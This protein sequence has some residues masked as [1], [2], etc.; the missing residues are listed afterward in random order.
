MHMLTRRL[1]DEPS[2]RYEVETTPSPLQASPT[3]PTDPLATATLIVVASNP[4][5]HATAKVKSVSI[6]FD[7]AA[8]GQADGATYLTS[9]GT[10][11]DFQVMGDPD[12]EIWARTDNGAGRFTAAARAG[13]VDVAGEGLAFILS[14]I[15]PNRGVGTFELTIEETLDGGGVQAVVLLVSKF[16]ASFTLTDFHAD[17]STVAQG[18]GTILRWDG[19]IGATLKIHHA[20][21][22][23]DVTGATHWPTG[24]L[25]RNSEFVL[26]ASVGSV[27]LATWS[28]TVE[29][30]RQILDL[31]SLAVERTTILKGATTVGQAAAAAPFVVNGDAGVTGGFTAHSAT[32]M[33]DLEVRNHLTVKRG[34]TGAAAAIRLLTPG[35]GCG[36]P[37]TY[38]ANTD[39]FLIG[40]VL[41]PK[42][43]SAFSMCWMTLKNADGVVAHAT[44]GNHACMGWGGEGHP[45]V[46]SGGNWN[47][48]ILPVRAG[49]E[50]YLSFEQSP[51]NNNPGHHEDDAPTATWWVPLG[52]SPGGETLTK[53]SDEVPEAHRARIPD[54]LT[55][56]LASAGR[57]RL[58]KRK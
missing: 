8:P 39:G 3:D 34:L 20:G 49:T 57:R 21:G 54:A 38:L 42:D 7:V 22:S 14:N 18:Q 45:V 5:Y 43:V 10:G 48:A 19:G 36:G 30:D 46:D 32:I 6:A 51:K 33:E 35:R 41:P 56:A 23:A 13:S 40:N 17:D 50:C 53:I 28:L 16:P 11:I 27:A 2:L 9:I 1:L 58:P 52:T 24:A 44:G 37:G 31:T 15:R 4:P 47:S 55:G 26:E 25:T 12:Q 29:V